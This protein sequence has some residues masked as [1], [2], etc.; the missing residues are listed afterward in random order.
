MYPK[1]NNVWM[2]YSTDRLPLPIE[3]EINYKKSRIE[4]GY[5]ISAGVSGIGGNSSVRMEYEKTASNH[6]LFPDREDVS[7]AVDTSPRWLKGGQL[8]I[9]G[10]VERHN[11]RPLIDKT[12]TLFANLT[13]PIGKKRAIPKERDFENSLDTSIKRYKSVD[14]Q[15]S[16]Y[17]KKELIDAMKTMPYNEFTEG[18]IKQNVNSVNDALSL[19]A[20]IGKRLHDYNYDEKEIDPARINTIS[21]EGIYNSLQESINTGKDIPA[22]VCRG[23]SRFMADMVNTADLKETSAYAPFVNMEITGDT[24]HVI[25]SIATPEQIYLVDYGEI[26]PIGSVD[27][28]IAH[29]MYQKGQGIVSVRHPVYSGGYIGDVETADTRLLKRVLSVQK[30]ISTT[31]MLKNDLRSIELGFDTYDLNAGNPDNYTTPVSPPA[32]TMPT[33]AIPTY[34][35]PAPLPA[36]PVCNITTPAVNMPSIPEPLPAPVYSMPAVTDN[37]PASS[38]NIFSQ[39]TFNHPSCFDANKFIID[40]IPTAGLAALP[41]LPEIP[42]VHI[43]EPPTYSPIKSASWDKEYSWD[44]GYSKIS[45]RPGEMPEQ[46]WNFF[47]NHLLEEEGRFC[48]RGFTNV[49][50]DNSNFDEMR[51]YLNEN[52]PEEK[53]F[54]ERITVLGTLFGADVN[55]VQSGGNIEAMLGEM[56]PWKVLETLTSED[57]GYPWSKEQVI[58]TLTD[59]AIQGKVEFPSQMLDLYSSVNQVNGP[60][61]SYQTMHDIARYTE[62]IGKTDEDYRDEVLAKLTYQLTISMKGNEQYTPEEQGDRIELFVDT[63]HNVPDRMNNLTMGGLGSLMQYQSELQENPS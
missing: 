20:I 38:A 55:Q 16:S 54:H 28:G 46:M 41:Q 44:K 24:G 27:P 51:F 10:V 21:N 57:S 62:H 52:D 42:T 33:L 35:S 19:A 22:T 34:D 3:T 45:I 29:Q 40:S 12:E 31:E 58:S 37:P 53:R 15:P 50:Y 5:T 47:S 63:C 26:I 7:I 61:A 23:I 6:N 56:P 43:P 60:K 9:G 17:S 36:A 8:S 49:S 18:F 59:L 4:D 39:D 25:V 30:G 11:Y 13:I 32:P 14:I 48:R 2:R 1:E